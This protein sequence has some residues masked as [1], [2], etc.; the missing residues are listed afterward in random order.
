MEI[1]QCMSDNILSLNEN[2]GSLPELISAFDLSSEEDYEARFV[3]I[4]LLYDVY[5]Q[6]RMRYLED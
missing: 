5:Y 3:K 4:V 2:D 6:D 1:L